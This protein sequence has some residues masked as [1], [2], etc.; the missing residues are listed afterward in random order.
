VSIYNLGIV[1]HAHIYNSGEAKEHLHVHVQ[2]EGIGKKGSN[3]VSL[4]IKKTLSDLNLLLND[5][6]GGELNIIFD[7]CSGQ[8][9][10][11]TVLKLAVWI[12]E[13]GYFKSINFILS[14]VSPTTTQMMMS[15]A[16]WVMI[17]VNQPWKQRMCNWR[18]GS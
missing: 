5:S 18:R 11:N 6:V 15:T 8:N 2:H 16:I 9:K 14:V 7:N 1:N 10:N 13:L 4:F 12:A 3:N 17:M